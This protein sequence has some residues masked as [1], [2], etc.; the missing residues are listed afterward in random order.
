ML[1]TAAA[2]AGAGAACLLCLAFAIQPRDRFSV[3]RR[4]RGMRHVDE[5]DDWAIVVLIV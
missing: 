5:R 1:T 4:A 3:V 2:G